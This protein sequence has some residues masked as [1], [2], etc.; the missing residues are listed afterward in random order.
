MLMDTDDRTNN[1]LGAL[2]VALGDAMRTGVEKASGQG[3]TA[4]AAL[5]TAFAFPGK[6]VDHLRR[7][8]GLSAAGAT[9]LVDKLQADGLIERRASLDDGRSRAV[10]LTDAGSKTAKSVL[11]ARRAVHSRALAALS[12]D[13]QNQLARMLDA[14]LTALTP[15]RA[16]CDLTCRLCDIAACPQDICPVELAALRVEEA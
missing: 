5:A 1:L 2:V 9:R 14:M 10:L 12:A 16:T 11:E 4:A 13:Q 7:I 3:V 15:D 8:L 6:S